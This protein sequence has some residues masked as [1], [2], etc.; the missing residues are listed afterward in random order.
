MHITGITP[1]LSES[2]AALSLEAVAAAKNAGVTV[3]CDF[4]FRGKLWKWGKSAPE[5]MTELARVREGAGGE[6]QLT[7][8]LAGTLD[9][10]DFYGLR[11]DGV[12]FDCGDKAGYLEANLA[13][14]LDR[15]DLRDKARD[16][17]ARYAA[18]GGTTS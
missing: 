15:D 3:S 12:R 2:A 9:R 1:A 11:F 7:D 17:L 18:K 4:N 14:A 16:I 5:V 6:I 13:F 10:V 8:A